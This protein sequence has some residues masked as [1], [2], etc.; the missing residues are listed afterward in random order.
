MLEL[1]IGSVVYLK[2]RFISRSLSFKFELAFPVRL[3]NSCPLGVLQLI[4][5]FVDKAYCKGWGT[6]Y[7]TDDAFEG[8]NPWDDPP[9]FWDLLVEATMNIPSVDSCNLDGLKVLAPLLGS[10]I[11]GEL[12][13]VAIV[14]GIRHFGL[15]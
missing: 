2:T 8:G 1:D 10:N 14:R 5:P 4:Q 11:D 13:I 3:R 9:T 15:W 12:L 6:I 7:V